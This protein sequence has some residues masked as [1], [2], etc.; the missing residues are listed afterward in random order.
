MHLAD[1]EPLKRAVPSK[2]YELMEAGIHVT[3]VVQGESAEIVQNQNAGIVVQPGQPELLARAWKL[4]AQEAGSLD[5]G[6]R[7][8]EW[9]REERNEIAPQVLLSTLSKVVDGNC[10]GL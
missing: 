10:C 7:G 2:T 1:W 5:I 9:V 4:L 6:S 8:S 3:A